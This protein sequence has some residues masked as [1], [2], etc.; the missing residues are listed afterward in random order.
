MKNFLKTIRHLLGG[1]NNKDSMPAQINIDAQIELIKSIEKKHKIEP[2]RRI[3][4]FEYLGFV[5]NLDLEVTNT[6]RLVAFEGQ[7][8]KYSFSIKGK[9]GDY[10]TLKSGLEQSLDFLSG[11]RKIVNLPKKDLLK[12]YYF[13]N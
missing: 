7:E 4:V 2:G 10:E 9:P 3:H 13:G 11:D 8:K 1:G 6:Y 12:G 5:L